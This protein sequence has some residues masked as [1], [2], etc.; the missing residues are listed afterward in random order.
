MDVSLPHFD[1]VERNE[2]SLRLDS[3]V[4]EFQAGSGRRA[5]LR[6]VEIYAGQNNTLHM[7]RNCEEILEVLSGSCEHRVGDKKVVFDEEQAPQI[8][9]AGAARSRG[10]AGAGDPRCGSRGESGDSG[11]LP[12][13]SH[14]R[15]WRREPACRSRLGK[16]LQRVGATRIY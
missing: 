4:D 7:H 1:R 14:G 11:D 13:R 10:R 5:N 6:I 2:I 15:A 12:R 16:A 9:A 8:T 3:V